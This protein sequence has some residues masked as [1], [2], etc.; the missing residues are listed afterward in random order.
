MSRVAPVLLFSTALAL[1]ASI[2]TRTEAQ[3]ASGIPDYFFSAWTVSRDC[4]EAHAGPRG[5]TLPGNQYR[6]APTATSDGTSYSLLAVDRPNHVWGSGWRNVK[7]EYRAGTP[8]STMPA[9]FS[10]VPGS[11]A[12]SSFL[13]QSGYSVSAEPYYGNEHWYGTVMLHGEKHHLL[14]FPTQTHGP[15]S[16]AIVLIDADA[17]DNLQLDTGGIIISEN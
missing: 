6:I 11:E 9:D 16:A 7:L 17:S 10:C 4:T 2:Q 13:A 15:A 14:I 5:H 3:T 1:M 8:M 12:S